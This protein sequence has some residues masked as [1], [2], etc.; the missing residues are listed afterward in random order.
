MRDVVISRI[1]EFCRRSGLAPATVTV[2]AVGN[3]RLYGRLK[4]GGD[5]TTAV[6]ARVLAWLDAQE[7]VGSE[8]VE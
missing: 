7:A 8:P 6:A 2:R 3:S 1:E 5:C 4:A